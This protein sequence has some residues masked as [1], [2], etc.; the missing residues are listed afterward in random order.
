MP[1]S[2]RSARPCRCRSSKR[3]PCAFKPDLREHG[4]VG[5]DLQLLLAGPRDKRTRRA[6]S[7][8]LGLYVDEDCAFESAVDRER[9]AARASTSLPMITRLDPH[10]STVL[11]PADMEQFAAEVRALASGARPAYLAP[12]M[13]LAEMCAATP[14]SELHIDGD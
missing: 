4:A 2:G 5:L 7:Q 1:L 8:R 10:G 12:I 9:G 13:V 6:T 14:G 3:Q 11:G